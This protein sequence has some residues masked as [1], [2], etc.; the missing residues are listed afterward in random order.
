MGVTYFT[1]QDDRLDQICFRYYGTEGN[2]NVEMVL[3]A[4][5]GLAGLGPI[6]EAGVLIFLPDLPA[7][8]FPVRQ[9]VHLWS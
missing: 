9:V 1:I 6:Y 5:R 8:T 4:N 7:P 3:D 2:G